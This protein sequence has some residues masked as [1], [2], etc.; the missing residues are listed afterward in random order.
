M[1]F[2]RR[3]LISAAEDL[4]RADFL[5]TYPGLERSIED[6]VMAKVYNEAP[7]RSVF[8]DSRPVSIKRWIASG[9]VVLVSLSTVVCGLTFDRVASVGGDSFL[10]PLGLTIG[11][12]VT[13]YGALF[14]GSHMEELSEHFGLRASS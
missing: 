8:C 11:G 14:I 1:F 13:I 5:P 2:K 3:R 6:A 10:L 12:I 9:L 7:F 4:L